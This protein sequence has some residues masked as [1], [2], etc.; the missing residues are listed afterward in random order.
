MKWERNDGI[1][2]SE[3]ERFVILKATDRLYYGRWELF[4]KITKEKY[5]GDS[6]KHAKQIAENMENQ[7]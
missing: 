7:N 3:N 5:H 1:Y 2:N 6:L 4:D